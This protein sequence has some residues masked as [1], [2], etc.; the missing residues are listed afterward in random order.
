MSTADHPT[1]YRDDTNAANG[2]SM[3][4]QGRLYSCEQDGHRVVRMEKDGRLT[5]IASEYEGKRL[6]SPNDV[7]VR[8]DGHVYFSDPASD[9]VLD[10]RELGF[11]GVYHVT[12]EGAISLVPKW[13]GP[14]ALRSPRMGRCFMLR[15]R[16]SER[17][18][19]TI[20]MLRGT[21]RESGC[22]LAASTAD[23]TDY[24]SRPMAIFTLL[25]GELRST[26]LTENSSR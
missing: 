2:N 8:R 22:S 13:P 12:P 24:G 18:W 26:R 25:A 4:S 7:V 23:R 9:A 6:N 5:V 3:D 19:H 16:N 17:S 11:N 20:S 15:I 1:V 14:T 10:P 21:P